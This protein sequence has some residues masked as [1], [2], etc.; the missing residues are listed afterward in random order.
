[1]FEP[2]DATDFATRLISHE[3]ADF[4]VRMYLFGRM[5]SLYTKV[6]SGN[7]SGRLGWLWLAGRGAF[8]GVW[9]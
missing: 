4:D 8:R 6:G 7:R 3:V 9:L 2:I 5:L 1:M